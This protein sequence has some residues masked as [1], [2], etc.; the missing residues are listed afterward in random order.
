MSG[1]ASKSDSKSQSQQQSQSTA[2]QQLDPDIKAALLGNY[3]SFGQNVPGYTPY[4]G[5]TVADFTPQQLQSFGMVGDI[6]NNQTGAAPLNAGI[7]TTQGIAHYAPQMVTAPQAQ[8]AQINPN[9]VSSVTAQ[10]IPGM[11][12]AA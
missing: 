2:Q 8:A 7:A 6:A 11:N 10:S 1:G 5:T 3:N 4:S 9:S 12:L